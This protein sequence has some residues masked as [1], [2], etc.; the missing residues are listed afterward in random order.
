MDEKIIIAISVPISIF[1]VAVLIGLAISG[2]KWGIPPFK[3]LYERRMK[4]M[5]GNDSKF[6]LDKVDALKDSPLKGKRSLCLGSSVTV[7]QSAM[8]VSFADYLGKRDGAIVT[9][10]AVS[11]TPLMDT[12]ELSYV[13]RLKNKVDVNSKFDLAIVQ[14]STNDVWCDCSLGEFSDN[15][16]TTYGAITFIVNYIKEHFKCPVM[17]YTSPY[18][19]CEKYVKMV[20]DLNEHKEELGI[21]I[22]DLFNNKE[23]NNITKDER[24]LYMADPVHPTK[25]GYLLWWLPVF[26]EEI[27]K[28][29]NIK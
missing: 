12:G 21:G 9:K 23:F 20:K 25:A 6:D 19:D 11:G 5:D 26:E 15:E 2:Y 8:L 7:G 29:L 10:E 14:L 17:F 1:L 13:S 27:I 18:F 28:Y 4:K 16:K 24:A 22:I 3:F